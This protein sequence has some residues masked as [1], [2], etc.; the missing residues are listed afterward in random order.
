MCGIL[1]PQKED[2]QGFYYSLFLFL[3]YLVCVCVCVC[4]C[5]SVCVDTL[6]VAVPYLKGFLLSTSDLIFVTLDAGL[7]ISRRAVWVM[8]TFA[9]C[10]AT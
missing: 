7:L 9:S 8:S 6:Y 4:T 3:V 5:V 10:P 2:A 1:T